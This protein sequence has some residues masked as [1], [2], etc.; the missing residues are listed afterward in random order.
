MRSFR[1]ARSGVTPST[2]IVGICLTALLGACR[3]A[4][5]PD[6]YGNVEATTVVVGSEAS[7]RLLRFV[8]AE[9]AQLDVGEV[10]ALVDTQP[11]ALQ[12][13][14]IAAQRAGSASR[15]TEI[16]Q[17]IDVLEVQRRI[18]QRGYE[19]T[20][21]LVAQQAAT[22]Q[23]LDQAERDYRVLVEQIEAAR[24][25]RHTVGQDVA[26][27]TARA[28]QVRDQLH[29]SQV[30]NP[31]RGT[32]LTTYVKAGEVVQTGQPLYK[33]ARLDTVELRAYVTEPQLA[34]VRI[35]QSA[36]VSFDAGNAARRTVAGTVAWIASEAEFTPT[37]IQTRDERGNLVYA[38][39]LRVPNADGALK[40]GMPADVTFGRTTT[41][42]R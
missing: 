26:A 24:A 15:G 7:G 35:G 16:A 22:A 31:L 30:T 19:R 17:Q 37:P 39:K 36:E 10:V 41:A 29:R 28:A 8:P 34:R 9:G 42:A 40:I 4:P 23:Q 11:L 18:A 14:Q 12:L 3:R 27:T 20:R 21:R 13:D 38:V 2:V 33:I 5:E 6:A 25:Q 1:W 32:V